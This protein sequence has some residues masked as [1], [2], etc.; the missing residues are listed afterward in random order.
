MIPFDFLYGTL[1]EQ[2]FNKINV[3]VTHLTLDSQNFRFDEP[4]RKSNNMIVI[5]DQEPVDLDIFYNHVY[6]KFLMSDTSHRILISSE[7]STE[8]D[9]LCND[10]GL[11]NV[12]YFYHGLL[13]HEW[14]RLHW[15]QDITVNTN[16]ERTYIT[17]NNLILDKRLHRANLI[18]ELHKRDLLDHGYASY[19]APPIDRLLKSVNTYKLLPVGHKQNLQSN[20]SMLRNSLV[21]DTSMPTGSLSAE[22]DISTIQKSFVNLVTETIF[23][24]NKQH[25]TE[26]IFKPIVAKMPFLLLGGVGNLAYLRKYGF[27]TFGDFWDESYDTISNSAE[28]MDAVLT[29]LEDLCKKSH[30]ELVGMKLEMADILEHN[31][32]HFYKGMRPIIVNE[33]TQGLGIALAES[34]IQYSPL[35]LQHLND[36]LTY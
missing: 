9:L 29:I 23:Y 30:A 18:V 1:K 27:K 31:F 32:N 6:R 11:K 34:G 19:N 10:Y 12:H 13:C 24:E 8:C 16:F 14:Y 28:R 17:Y 4:N 36:I 22:L 25:L 3:S 7:Y 21:I 2:L 5:Y 35:D 33:L 20:L 26:K 15:Y